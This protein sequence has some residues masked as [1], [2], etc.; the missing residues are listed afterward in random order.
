MKNKWKRFLLYLLSFSLLLCGVTSC[1]APDADTGKEPQD[2]NGN[3]ESN[4]SH[5]LDGKRFLFIG[6]SYV[7]YGNTVI[8]KDKSLVE[9]KY[10]VNDTGYFY[11]LCRANGAEVSVTN[12]T[13][14][15][16]KLGHLFGAPCTCKGSCY[17][18]EHEKYLDDPYYDYV[19]VS[20]GGGTA[21]EAEIA[22][23]FAYITDFFREA[24]PDVKIV[25]LANEAPYR[26]SLPGIYTHYKVLE[27]QGVIIAE[28][29]KMLYDISNGYRTVEGMTHEVT[30]SSFFV[31][32][33]Y[34]PN[35]LTG[36]LTSLTLY[37]TLTGESAVGQTYAFCRDTSLGKRFD[38]A[39]FKSDY[40]K[41]LTTN[42]EEIMDTEADMRALQALVDTYIAE[43][44][45]RA[46]TA[47]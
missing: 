2:G 8:A 39:V 25:C 11:Q 10:R 13:F 37:C 27:E 45:Y 28:W 38:M 32:D 22:Q 41:T 44:P 35:P 14:G 18:V 15:G 6:N 26:L 5:P 1:N 20:P 3:G 16:H 23:D 29:G 36:Y 43:K 21:S 47:E 42:F 24:N 4:E 33:G 17:G 34:H 9:Q 19:I 30:R 7:Y 12:W 40:Y 31:D 46:V